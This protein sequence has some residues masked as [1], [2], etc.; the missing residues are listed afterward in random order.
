[1]MKHVG[2]IP[3]SLSVLASKSFDKKLLTIAV[4]SCQIWIFVNLY[5][6]F[7]RKCTHLYHIVFPCSWSRNR[8]SSQTHLHAPHS[9]TTVNHILGI[10]HKHP[11]NPLI[12]QNH[13]TIH[14]LQIYSSINLSTH[15]CMVRQSTNQPPAFIH[16]DATRQTWQN[17]TYNSWNAILE[18]MLGW[19]FTDTRKLIIYS[20]G[21]ALR[22]IANKWSPEAKPISN[23]AKLFYHTDVN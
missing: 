5:F 14:H 4:D 23:G 16:W 2:C 19:I 18:M 9:C 20:Y 3:A 12:N 7:F 11:V 15:L 8:R 6:Q 21:M 1:M 10:N 17:E 13:R 22:E